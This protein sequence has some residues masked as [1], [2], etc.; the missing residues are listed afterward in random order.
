LASPLE[1]LEG[2]RENYLS[3]VTKLVKNLTVNETGA[4]QVFLPVFR[5]LVAS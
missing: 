3:H 1:N 2:Y 5:L 4:A